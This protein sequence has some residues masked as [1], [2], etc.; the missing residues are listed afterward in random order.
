[1]ISSSWLKAWERRLTNSRNYPGSEE[2]AATFKFWKAQA[3]RKDALE[4]K[5]DSL[6]YLVAEAHKS[7]AV[8]E[9]E[10]SIH[11]HAVNKVAYT[12]PGK[13]FSRAPDFEIRVGDGDDNRRR[14]PVTPMNVSVDNQF[15]ENIRRNL[16][17]ATPQDRALSDAQVTD[18]LDHVFPDWNLFFFR[19]D[20]GLE[21]GNIAL[22]R[23]RLAEQQ[24]RRQRGLKLREVFLLG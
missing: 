5:V 2:I 14:C 15:L 8:G 19:Y 18:A 3:A 6:T 7:G 24:Q 21:K 4:N 1:M 11:R 10:V 17:Q 12:E 16:G 9:Q 20:D 22:D 13:Q 23:R